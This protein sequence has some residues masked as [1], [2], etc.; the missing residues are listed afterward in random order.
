MKIVFQDLK[1]VFEVKWMWLPTFIGLNTPLMRKLESALTNKY[2][3][4]PS[5]EAL[6]DEVNEFVFSW[7]AQQFPDL[8]GLEQYLRGVVH[9]P[10]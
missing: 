1:G 3:E 9:I 5:T 8:H 6:L 7:L 4:R 10:E 2:A